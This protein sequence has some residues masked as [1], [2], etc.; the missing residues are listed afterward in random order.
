M[1][2]AAI[3]VLAVFAVSS[4]LIGLY[5]KFVEYRDK[6]ALTNDE[7]EVGSVLS[8]LALAFGAILGFLAWL[9]SS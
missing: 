2:L 3:I 9:L 6:P 5:V 4:V 1:K 8:L 7:R